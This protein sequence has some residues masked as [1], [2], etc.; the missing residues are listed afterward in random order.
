FTDDDRATT[1]PVAI[2]GE[3]FA[4]R[5]W[6]GQS[7]IGRRLRG[8]TFA[9]GAAAR[10]WMTVVGVAADVRY[11]ELRSPSMDLYVPYE[12]SEFSIGDI[13]VRTRGPA[14]LA[15]A[16][17]H[18]QVR[19]VDLDGLVRVTSMTAEVAREE[20]PWRTGL[21]LFVFFALFTTLLAG[22]GLYALLSA[23]VAE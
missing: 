1:A 15:S 23:T 2:V 10:P 14:E 11:R 4:R 22:V 3:T 8:H 5:T 19:A 16:A 9:N 17:V 21:R 20:A 12:Q 13:M 18:A 7:A 6:P